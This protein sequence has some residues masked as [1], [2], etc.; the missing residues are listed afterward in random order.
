[1]EG[2]MIKLVWLVMVIWV[3][4]MMTLM[5]AYRSSVVTMN[6]VSELSNSIDE[7]KYSMFEEPSYRVNQTDDQ[8]LKLQLI[9]ALRLQMSATYEQNW[10]TLDMGQ[11]LYTTDRFVEQMQTFLDN[12]LEL[13]ALVDQIQTL[14]TTYQKDSKLAGYYAQLGT[15]VLAAL[16]SSNQSNPQVFRELDQ[17]YAQ[18]EKLPVLQKKHLQHL[19]SKTSALLG[20]YAQGNYAI[21]KI[22]NNSIYS[23]I[24]LVESDFHAQQNQFVLSG[25]VLSGLC[26]LAMLGVSYRIPVGKSEGTQLEYEQEEPEEVEEHIIESQEMESISESETV[27]VINDEKAIDEPEIDLEAMLESLGGDHESV[28]ML[29][30]VFV[31]DHT[32]DAEKIADLLHSSPEEALRKAHSLKGVGGNL[33]APKLREAAGKVEQAIKDG[34]GSVSELL[35][36]LKIRLD[37]AIDE[38]QAFLNQQ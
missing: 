9:H 11:L 2:K 22:M 10:L 18:S 4:G 33:G 30:Q 26:L 36:E 37:K 17:I 14:R 21:E 27:P 15:N 12:E 20:S 29:L 38:A 31:D 28:C 8:A 13:V 24:A 23:Q 25:L 1:M 16:F 3:L 19:L 32:G 5:F 6:Q 35:D 7:L 34:T